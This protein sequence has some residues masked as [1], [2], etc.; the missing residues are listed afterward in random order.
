MNDI[1]DFLLE[2]TENSLA[3][4]DNDEWEELR[5]LTPQETHQLRDIDEA[6]NELETLKAEVKKL[7]TPERR[8]AVRSRRDLTDDELELLGR[9]MLAR[10][11]FQATQ[12]AFWSPLKYEFRQIEQLM[13]DTE[14][15]LAM[16]RGY[17]RSGRQDLNLALEP[18]GIPSAYEMKE[19]A[20]LFGE[21]AP[22]G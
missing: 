20:R 15:R 10:D 7:L 17:N 16:G 22:E 6:W 13:L 5:S 3:S 12:N 9:L 21:S 4:I 2:I 18:V 14:R 8:R 11:V 19:L 1:T